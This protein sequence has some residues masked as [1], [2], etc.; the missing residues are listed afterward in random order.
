MNSEAGAKQA[1]DSFRCVNSDNEATSALPSPR[2]AI[3][4]ASPL[5]LYSQI[6]VSSA[7]QENMDVATKLA[8]GR[9]VKTRASESRDR[10]WKSGPK[11][12]TYV[13]FYPEQLF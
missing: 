6:R 1:R 9:I 8:Q 3:T 12:P 10:T 4:N 7:V 13:L 5:R 11:Y 2:T